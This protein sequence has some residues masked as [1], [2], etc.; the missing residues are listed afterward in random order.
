MIISS[1]YILDIQAYNAVGDVN[2]SL[3]FILILSLQ[4]KQWSLWKN[5]ES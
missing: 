3:K 4:Q 2:V 5:P 1:G